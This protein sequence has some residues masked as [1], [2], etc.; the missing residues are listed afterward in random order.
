MIDLARRSGQV[1]KIE[2]RI[3]RK[4][5]EFRLDYGAERIT[6]VPA[7]TKKKAL[8]TLTACNQA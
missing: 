8:K 5:D 3:V 1:K 4:G 7:T 6:H 2:A